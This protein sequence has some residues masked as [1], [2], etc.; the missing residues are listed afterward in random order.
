MREVFLVKA[1]LLLAD[2]PWRYADGARLPRRGRDQRSRARA[3]RTGPLSLPDPPAGGHASWRPEFDGRLGGHRHHA[4]HLRPR[5]D[6]RGAVGDR[7]GCAG[8]SPSPRLT[9]D[10]YWVVLASARRI[11]RRPSRWRGASGTVS[12]PSTVATARNGWHAITAGPITA[13][14]GEAAVTAALRAD[15]TLPGRPLPHRR[16]PAFFPTPFWSADRPRLERLRYGGE[17]APRDPGGRPGPQRSSRRNGRLRPAVSRSRRIAGPA[18]PPSPWT[19]S[20]AGPFSASRLDHPSRRSSRRAPDERP[21][22]RSPPSPG[23]A[24]IAAR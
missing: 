3:R 22:R 15:P 2:G 9:D 19:M 7:R 6:F 24:P 1:F 4:R 14:D 18:S 10:A 20:D 16:A 13:P 12:T 11:R 23:G 5:G 8:E 21:D 17:G